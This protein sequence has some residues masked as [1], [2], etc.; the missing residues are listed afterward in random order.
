MSDKLGVTINWGGNQVSV[1]RQLV[2]YATRNSYYNTTAELKIAF[3]EG[4][5]TKA[6]FS[7]Y[8]D[9][10]FSYKPKKNIFLDTD[11][12]KRHYRSAMENVISKTFD[13]GVK[14]YVKVRAPE[15][16]EEYP[17]LTE[18]KIREQYSKKESKTV[19]QEV[20]RITTGTSTLLPKQ[21]FDPNTRLLVFNKGQIITDEMIRQQSLNAAEVE[22]KN[23]NYKTPF[24][25]RNNPNVPFTY[26]QHEAFLQ[27]EKTRIAQDFE[28]KFKAHLADLE[29]KNIEMAKVKSGETSTI[30]YERKR[31]KRKLS[32]K[33]KKV[34]IAPR[35][36]TTIK[37]VTSD[38]HIRNVEGGKPILPT[39]QVKGPAGTTI[40]EFTES[41]MNQRI[42]VLKNKIHGKL[43]N[44]R[45]LSLT[46]KLRVYEIQYAR[47]Y[48]KAVPS[49]AKVK[50][51]ATT[52]GRVGK[53][54]L[55]KVPV[56]AIPFEIK[57]M[58]KEYEQIMEGEH[59]MFP[60]AEKLSQQVYKKGGEVP[61][62]KRKPYA[63]GGK[64]YSQSI[65]KPRLI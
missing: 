64:V 30:T 45:G 22:M 21:T 19:G 65:R 23:R 8:K 26:H 56:V 32:I 13:K 46:E 48:K 16:L 59:P 60:S 62:K 9:M 31:K 17:P 53:G 58:K 36:T 39:Q 35:K 38:F 49:W 43:P 15:L 6:E 24:Q 1:W 3:A 52:I 28:N 5:I 41:E 47:D 25:V 33:E 51:V 20:K 7:F 2:W 34:I 40:S 29:T 42:K 11:I 37:Q 63:V 57:R 55:K 12:Q 61:S 10:L 44:T 50:K 14:E 27:N 4:Q 54:I 18:D